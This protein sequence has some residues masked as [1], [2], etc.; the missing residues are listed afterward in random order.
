MENLTIALKREKLEIF[1]VSTFGVILGPRGQLKKSR[2]LHRY[3]LHEAK[4]T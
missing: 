2:N 1:A 3:K 4:L